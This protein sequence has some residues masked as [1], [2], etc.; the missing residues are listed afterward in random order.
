MSDSIFEYVD[1]DDNTIQVDDIY[2][3]P[4]QYRGNVLVIG[5]DTPP[6]EGAVQT[7]ETTEKSG[8]GFNINDLQ[9]YQPAQSHYV[10]LAAAIIFLK[11]KNFLLKCVLGGALGLFVLYTAGTW[12]SSSD[13]MKTNIDK[14]AED[15]KKSDL[16]NKQK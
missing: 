6:E 8:G 14:L 9:N 1:K 3:V 5:L 4:E 10:A 13:Y 2:K 15:G 11:T 7:T 16:L 12:F